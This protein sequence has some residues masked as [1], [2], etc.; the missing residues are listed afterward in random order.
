[1]DDGDF[2]LN[3]SDLNDDAGLSLIDQEKIKV[4]DA[5][6]SYLKLMKDNVRFKEKEDAKINYGLILAYQDALTLLDNLQSQVDAE[7]STITDEEITAQ[8]QEIEKHTKSLTYEDI[9][10]Y[11]ADSSDDEEG[12]DMLGGDKDKPDSGDGDTDW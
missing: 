11:D 8:I 3:N 6:E 5:M 2:E 4:I 12:L 10:K 1:M 7:D 9:S